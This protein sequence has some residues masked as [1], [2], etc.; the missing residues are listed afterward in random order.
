VKSFAQKTC[1]TKFRLKFGDKFLLEKIDWLPTYLQFEKQHGLQKES[2]SS[3]AT[4]WM[5]V[6][7]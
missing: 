4:L 1:A 2:L 6:S 3:K 7:T 5:K